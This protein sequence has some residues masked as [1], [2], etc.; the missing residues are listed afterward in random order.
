MQV[1]IFKQGEEKEWD[2]FVLKSENATF[3][4]LSAWA[5]VIQQAYGHTPLYLL[6]KEGK[7]I[8]GVLPCFLLKHFLFGRRIVSMPFFSFGGLLAENQGIACQLLKYLEK[9]IKENGYETAEIRSDFLLDYWPRRLRHFTFKLDLRPGEERLFKTIYRNLRN[10]I[11]KS[12]RQNFQIEIGQAYLKDFHQ[13][14]QKTVL[15]L[16]TPVHSLAFWQEIVKTFP[17]Q[18]VVL[19]VKHKTKPAAGLF[20]FKFKETVY[21]LWA[22]SDKKYWEINV[23]DCLFW[24]AIRYSIENGFSYFDFGRSQK[25]SGTYHFKAQF[26]PEIKQLYYH[27]YPCQNQADDQEKKLKSFV[28]F[29]QKMPLPLANYFGPKLRKFIP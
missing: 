9:Y 24:Q 5:P 8:K 3:A 28:K 2:D 15:R 10:Q 19:L 16:G 14:Y 26:F 23:N 21:A 7:E 17:N 22:A 18:A 12:Q 6:A 13:L 20:L 29:W 4:S 11:R 25:N 1:E 27:Y